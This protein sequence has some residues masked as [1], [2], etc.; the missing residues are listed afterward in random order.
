MEVNVLGSKYTIIKSTEKEYPYLAESDGFCDPSVRKIVIDISMP[1]SISACENQKEL[2]ERVL[3][4]ELIHAFL[5]ESGLAQSS[6]AD[7]E[8]MV[9]WIARQFPKMLS[10]MR[11][12]DCI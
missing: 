3:R 5:F 7:N 10:A 8:E 12:A 6:W 4:H 1:N 11:S 2:Q 9:D